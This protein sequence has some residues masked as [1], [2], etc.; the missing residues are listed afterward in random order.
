ML[1]AGDYGYLF[2]LLGFLEQHISMLQRHYFVGIT[3]DQ[4]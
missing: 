3:M 2:R 1:S 4:E